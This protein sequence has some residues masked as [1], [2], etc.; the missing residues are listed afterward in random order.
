MIHHPE[1]GSKSHLTDS[2]GEQLS[3]Y[4]RMGWWIIPAFSPDTE[5]REIQPD[6]SHLPCTCDSRFDCLSVG[7]H[8]R[9]GWKYRDRSNT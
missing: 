8:T 2:V 6:I 3:S 5:A 1:P 9:S 7:K 4:V